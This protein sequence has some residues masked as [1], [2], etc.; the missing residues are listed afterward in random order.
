M[1]DSEQ[2]Y[3]EFL[4]LVGNAIGQWAYIE[5]KLLDIFIRAI[6]VSGEKID[7]ARAAYHAT[8]NFRIKLDMTNAALRT[9]LDETQAQDWGRIYRRLEKKA[10]KRAL[11]S[12]SHVTRVVEGVDGTSTPKIRPN[13]TNPTKRQSYFSG[14][15]D[16]DSKKLIEITKDF[17]QMQRDLAA[18]LKELP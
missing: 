3:V 11:V 18:F 12:H 15:E 5:D 16:I 6:G 9:Y 7:R 4:A 1:A 10:R 13:P 8:I 14:A 17:V 2:E